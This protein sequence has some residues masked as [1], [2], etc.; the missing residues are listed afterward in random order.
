MASHK[1]LPK[2]G[3][4]M[5]FA[6]L[7]SGRGSNMLSLADVIAEHSML[8]SLVLVAADK[9]C[10]GLALAK[11][12]GLSTALVAYK[13]RR[14]QDSEA[15]LATLL[16]DHHID[17]IL[18]A[19][20]MRV[21]S[22]D[23]VAQFPNRIINI[24]PSLLPKYKGLETHKRAIAAGDTL[25]GATVHLVTAGLDEGPIIAAAS[26]EI[27]PDD[28]ERSLAERLLPIE[29]ALYGLVITALMTGDLSIDEKGAR[30]QA[31]PDHHLI[32]GQW[33]IPL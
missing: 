15:E 6:I 28:D 31:Q 1:R 11:E 27:A 30:W 10:A 17:V 12:R 8:G 18:L 14:K 23:F 24:H 5:R 7:I 2:M 13:G 4:G 33:H 32:N 16:R 29:H 26:C 20:F 22:T 19:G 9:S 25:H 3:A 21:L